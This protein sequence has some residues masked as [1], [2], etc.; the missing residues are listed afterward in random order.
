M[1][2][3]DTLRDGEVEIRDLRHAEE[4][5]QVVD[6]FKQI[7]GSRTELVRLEILMAIS[8]SG[9]YVVG[10]FDRRDGD[11]QETIIGASVG[12]LARR[13]DA[14]ALH[15]HITG[16]LPGVRSTGLGRRLKLHQRTWAIEHGLDWIV[17]TFDPLVRGNAWF[18]IA[19]LGAEVDEYLDCFYGVMTDAINAGD[20]SDRL[21]VAW[22]VTIDP[23]HPLYD[24]SGVEDPLLIPT[25]DDVVALRRTDPDAIARWRRETRA[26]WHAALDEGRR[27]EGFTRDGHYVLGAPAASGASG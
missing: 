20:E 11:E 12:L 10:A 5:A 18:N 3:S 8:H 14:P 1:D 7:W 16:V 22:D 6:L 15:S 2:T 19:V 17:W 23:D 24:G 25:P 26:S 13:R 4:M 27:V 21:L 9:G